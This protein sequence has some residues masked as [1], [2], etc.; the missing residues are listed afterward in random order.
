MA[1]T[2]FKRLSAVSINEQFVEYL[3]STVNGPL[4]VVAGYPGSRDSKLSPAKSVR[5][6]DNIRIAPS[7]KNNTEAQDTRWLAN[8]DYSS[9]IREYSLWDRYAIST[10][11]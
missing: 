1:L 10:R 11:V 5:S 8:P 7:A 6:S 9:W 3:I 2:S 4:R